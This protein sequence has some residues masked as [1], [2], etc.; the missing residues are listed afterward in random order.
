MRRLNE[1]LLA[2]G[3]KNPKAEMPFLDHLEELRWRI[4]WSV[5]AVVACTIVGLVLILY[6]DVVALLIRPAAEVYAERGEELQLITLAPEQ[7]FFFLLQICIASGLILASP[8]V[9]SQ[10][11][12]FFAPALEDHEKRALVPALMLGLVLFVAG[13]ALAY[14]LALPITLRFLGGLLSD[15]LTPNWS[16]TGYLGFVIK[17]LLAFGVVFELPVVVMLL[18]ALGIVTPGFLRS[19]RRH[20]IVVILIIASLLSPGDVISITAMMMVPLVLLYEFSIWLSVLM[21]KRRDSQEETTG[22]DDDDGDQGPDGGPEAGG[23]AA[24]R[25]SAPRA[26]APPSDAP[27]PDDAVAEP[28]DHDL[29][30]G[31]PTPYDYGDPA[32]ESGGEGDDG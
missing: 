9:I 21:W 3:G 32:R 8:I 1:G 13:V 12:K 26:S 14:F 15:F 11:W 27:P 16:A 4:L 18:S 5:V 28:G 22:A 29:A 31:H 6:F 2:R 23:P 25:S 30:P 7:S 24:P 10:A 20:A 19:K 17:L